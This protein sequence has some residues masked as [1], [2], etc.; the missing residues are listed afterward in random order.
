VDIAVNVVEF[1][2]A[3]GGQRISL[4]E[5][6]GQR[7]TMVGRMSSEGKHQQGACGSQDSAQ[8]GGGLAM[9]VHDF[10]PFLKA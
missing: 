1:D 5:F 2:A 10:L 6:F 9:A 8:P 4:M 3:I 7:A